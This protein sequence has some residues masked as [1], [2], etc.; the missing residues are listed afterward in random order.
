MAREP[1]EI[2]GLALRQ[3]A[4]HEA[5]VFRVGDLPRNHSRRQR[6]NSRPDARRRLD[7]YLL[8]D[9]RPR[10]R[11]ERLAA[12]LERDA[13]KIPNDAREH[14]AAAARRALSASP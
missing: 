9:D 1:R 8:T 11:E 5:G 3:A 7:G 6:A 14:G 13:G 4:G 2:F 12:G 10:Q